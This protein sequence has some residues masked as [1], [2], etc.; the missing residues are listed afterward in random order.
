[1]N[2]IKGIVFNIERYAVQDGPGIRTTVFL[3]GCPLHCVWCHN[4]EGI[5]PE[6][7]LFFNV[8]RCISCGDCIKICPRGAI[9]GRTEK[10]SVDREICIR[11][12]QCAKVC[13]S[14]ALEEIGKEMSVEE[15]V[16]QT[17]AD[18]LSYQMSG[19]GVTFSGGEPLLQQAFLK[20]LLK[21]HKELGMSTAV[22]TSF[23]GKWSDIAELIQYVDLFLIDLKIVDAGRLRKYTKA[24]AG[25]I[26]ENLRKIFLTEIPVVIRI[27]LIPG[28]TTQQ[29]NIDS[30]LEFLTR[31]KGKNLEYISLLP[32][33]RFGE[34][35]A[36]S[37]G[38]LRELN[39]KNISQP[40]LE[41]VKSQFEQNGFLVKVGL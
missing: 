11:C 39:I 15:V 5:N 3:K 26:L 19:G 7:E 28:Y 36:E 6:P 29:R 2:T 18:L 16:R 17:S 35:K 9:S 8:K 4:P 31:H 23:S 33:H 21:K 14:G 22:E 25:L 40:F 24:S 30:I 32:F 1:M 20:E 13:P 37:L 38:T 10:I 34:A 12:F 41:K 27:P